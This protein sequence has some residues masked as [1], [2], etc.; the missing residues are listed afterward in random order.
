MSLIKKIVG[1]TVILSLIGGGAYY[2]L[3]SG[4][5]KKVSYETY[6]VNKGTIQEIVS[7]NGS[8][9]AASDINL[10]FRSTGRV[11]QINV[12]VGDQVIEGQKLAE[13]DNFQANSRVA[14][15]E[16]NVA[17]A[18]SNR[19]RTLAGA[20]IEE[21]NVQRVNIQNA[22]KSVENNQKY[23]D[24]LKK[25]SEE[26]IA[27]ANLQITTQESMV[28]EA[29]R[30][31]AQMQELT[32]NQIKQA[33]LQ[34]TNAKQNVD[35]L[36]KILQKVK[37]VNAQNIQQTILQ[38]DNAA[39][40]LAELRSQRDSLRGDSGATV[41]S[42]KSQLDIQ[43]AQAQNNVS[44]AKKSI[45]VVS[46]QSASQEEQSQGQVL[47][48]ELQV[49]ASEAALAVLRSQVKS[50]L[51]S[52][53]SALDKAKQSL[54]A[55]KQNGEN[56]LAQSSVRIATADGQLIASQNQLALG[57]AQLQNILAE[58]REVDL[59]PLEA[60]V[61]LAKAELSL[62][63][64]Q[65]NDLIITAPVAGTISA[66]NRKVGEDAQSTLPVLALLTSGK[67]QIEANVSESDIAR[68]K[69]GNKAHITF[70]A[71]PEDESVDGAVVAIDPDSTVV[72]GVIYYRVTIYFDSKPEQREL[73]K[74][75][76][77]ANLSITTRIAED[78][79]TIPLQAVKS[80]KN[81]QSVD[82]LENNQVINKKIVT[83]IRGEQSVEV[84]QGISIGEAVIT[85]IKNE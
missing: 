78:V 5:E 65:L 80:D 23:V 75:G 71:L 41:S 27:T 72:S 46:S 50:Q 70:D 30:G 4:K 69:I 17:L 84:L 32:S 47:N 68:L 13:L 85:L 51:Q 31:L 25:Q 6:T 83:G 8:V 34:V 81:G 21:V 67:L 35:Q 57:E 66:V 29:E 61:A 74:P 28:V 22:R 56:V 60:Q 82:V 19:D 59:A 48:A 53:E 49:S 16:T 45:E 15:A 18:T 24:A 54:Q 62:A 10:N 40:Y 9:M 3:G 12:R 44:A 11:K 1:F 42:Q 63:Q 26:E 73:I 64:E 55:A 52:A 14:Q 39:S 77:T 76:M 79:I 2:L 37:A 33:E 36:K 43:I 7:V 20:K 58:T 38:S